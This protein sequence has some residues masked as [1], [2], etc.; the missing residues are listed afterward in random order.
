MKNRKKLYIL[1]II[2]AA[3]LLIAAIPLIK[4]LGPVL[5]NTIT[6]I[7]NDTKE[8]Y[9]KTFI[10]ILIIYV[11][12]TIVMVIPLNVLYIAAGMILPPLYAVII[13]YI[14]VTVEMTLG[15]F[16]GRRIKQTNTFKKLGKNKYANKVMEFGSSNSIL[17]SML[18]RIVKGPPADLTSILMGSTGMNY[19]QY[20]LGTLIGIT[21]GMIPV[22]F[23]GKAVFNPFSAE[24]FVPLVLYLI[25][26]I[27]TFII[28]RNK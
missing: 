22:I 3:I 9:T 1:I 15:F 13:S 2:A 12:K 17:S 14:G 28:F 16:I 21:P 5:L 7:L 20:I 10:V 18:V 23:M 19:P 4:R 27:V 8:S 11:I 24:F 26:I 6:G 25:F